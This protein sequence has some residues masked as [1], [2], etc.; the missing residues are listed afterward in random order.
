M[1]KRFAENTFFSQYFC[2]PLKKSSFL[3]SSFTRIFHLVLINRVG[4]FYYYY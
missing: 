3:Q 4:F 2:F 1:N